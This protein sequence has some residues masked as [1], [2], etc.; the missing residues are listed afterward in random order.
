MLFGYL[1]KE[2]LT[3]ERDAMNLLIADSGSTK[4]EWILTG[5]SSG[6]KLFRSEGLNP[7]FCSKEQMVNEIGE[8][9]NQIG[10]ISVDH[11]YFYGAGSSDP[12]MQHIVSEALEA[13]FLNAEVEVKSD[14]LGA[15]RS[16]FG[17][18]S[19]I[20]CILGT[21]SNSCVYD[22]IDI[23]D[24]L[25]SLGFVLGDEGSGGY[26]GKKI[27][28][29]YY[30]N[31]MPE[32][33]QRYLETKYNM[34]LEYTLDRVYRK[35]RGNA[36]IASFASLLTVF[37]DHEFIKDLVEK[38]TRDFARKQLAYFQKHEVKNVGMV[39]SIASIHRESIEKELVKMGYELEI[40]I[41]KPIDELVSYHLKHP[42]G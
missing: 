5:E 17:D 6:N 35:P 15:A 42:V 14:L 38:G 33:L 32:E 40:V 2:F 8:L 27:V 34:D 22:G 23:V 16:L 21:G 39:G 4:T 19:G 20:A 7:Y 9:K 36:Y 11:I 29:N 31:R 26:F 13:H 24:R 10:N 25:P 18:K 12:S 41:Q 1:Y 28:R 3:P 30:Y 37:P